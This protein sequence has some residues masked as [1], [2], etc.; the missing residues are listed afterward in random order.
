LRSAADAFGLREFPRKLDVVR[1]IA[2]LLAFAVFGTVSCDFGDADSQERTQATSVE[3]VVHTP[4]C[5]RRPST[6]VDLKACASERSARLEEQ[7][8]ER[9]R[10]I[11]SRLGSRAQARLMRAER[12]WDTYRAAKCESRSDYYGE[13]GSARGVLFLDCLADEA[14]D[15]LRE[16]EAFERDVR[17]R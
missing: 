16:L 1:R 13:D 15:H 5:P 11:S 12:A 9:A 4:R 14:A 7:I 6:T 10:S 3:I 2:A 8:Q 17:E